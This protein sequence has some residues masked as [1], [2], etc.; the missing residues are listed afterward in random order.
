[1][2]AKIYT[3]NGGVVIDIDRDNFWVFSVRGSYIYV[4]ING[5][6]AR[7]ICRGLKPTGDTLLKNDETLIDLVRRE[8]RT[9]NKLN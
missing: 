3:D 6:A 4:S 7:Q 1:M 9:W 2:R 8:W 5:Q